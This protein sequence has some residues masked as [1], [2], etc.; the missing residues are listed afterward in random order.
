MVT[1][2]KAA[3]T[4]AATARRARSA[5]SSADSPSLRESS[6]ANSSPPTR[7][8]WS[9]AA[10]A[11]QPVRGLDEHAVADGIAV[12]VVDRLEVVE[13]EQGEGQRP[14]VARA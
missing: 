2:S 14:P 5:A 8:R 6:H 9:P 12:A 4:L 3:M 7:A 11:A 10:H 1:P 13:V